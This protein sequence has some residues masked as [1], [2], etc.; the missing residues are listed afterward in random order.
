MKAW[1]IYTGNVH[2]AHPCVLIS[3][4]ARIDRKPQV[5][6]LQCRTL[7]PGQQHEAELNEAILDEA[8]GLDWKT[9][10]RCDLLYTLDKVALTHKRGAVCFQRRRDIARKIMQGLAIAGL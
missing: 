7:Q 3:C 5:V 4:Q 8:D 1:D 2:G 9:I 10:C 6:V